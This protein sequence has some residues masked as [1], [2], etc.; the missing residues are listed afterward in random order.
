MSGSLIR[1]HLGGTERK[2]GWVNLNIQQGSAVDV[3]GTCD[4]LSMF[5]DG[6]CQLVYAS[7]VLE[8]LPL[9]RA[10]ACAKE[11][12]RVLVPGGQFLVSVPNVPVVLRLL[13]QATEPDRRFFLMKVIFGGD[14]DPYDHHRFGYDYE[15]AKHLFAVCGFTTLMQV[16][17][18]A[19]FQDSSVM[20]YEGTPLSLNLI[21]VK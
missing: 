8:H 19:L 7:H 21:A 10:F 18:F 13:A 11:V 3:V 6:S 5:A 1:L 16:D 20:E 12:R 17:A 15:I 9:E 14:A 2:P 4:D